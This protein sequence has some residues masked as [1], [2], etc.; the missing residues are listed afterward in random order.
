M[1]IIDFFDRLYSSQKYDKSGTLKLGFVYSV[2]RTFIRK[3]SNVII[4]IVLKNTSVTLSKN[5]TE[6]VIVSL[7]SFPLRIAK[8]WLVLESLLRQTVKPSKI[9]VWLSKKQFPT[10]NSIP[11][12]LLKYREKGID[13]EFVEDDYRSH[14]KYYYVLNRYPNAILVTLDDDIMYPSTMLEKLLDAHKQWPDAVIARYAYK[15]VRNEDGSI[16]P[17]AKWNRIMFPQPPT[18]DV[19]FGSGGGTLFPVGA[20][21]DDIKNIALA[22][23]LCP[24][25]D[26]VFLN[27]QCRINNTLIAVVD[28]KVALLNVQYKKNSRLA[29]NN[30]DVGNANDIQINAVNNYYNKNIF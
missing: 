1:Q 10:E 27:S 21:Y 7:T 30:I 18:N 8:L 17:Y 26:D 23:Q 16:A 25:A 6:E 24:T 20:F 19:F 22:R 13:I 2:L 28:S 3:F 15:M 11:S 14:K 5:S 12:S 9:I 4:P 29:T